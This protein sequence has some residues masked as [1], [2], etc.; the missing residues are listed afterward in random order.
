MRSKYALLIAVI[1][2]IA[3]V[4][5]AACLHQHPFI[6]GFLGDLLV[7]ILVY[8]TVL[9]FFELPPKTLAIAVF[10]FATLIEV[11][12]YFHLADHLGLAKGSI[13]RIV[14]GTTFSWF[15]LLAYL[16][17]CLLALGLHRKLAKD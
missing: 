17:G 5:I 9:V 14:V 2:F 10:C 11:G 4:L 7:V 6:R 12:Q 15:D 16:I 3:E 13:M 8:Y 1:V